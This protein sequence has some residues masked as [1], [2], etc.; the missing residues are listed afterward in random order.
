[1]FQISYMEETKV[2][3]FADTSSAEALF[4]K[5]SCDNIPCYML[6]DGRMVKSANLDM[7]DVAK[8]VVEAETIRKEQQPTIDALLYD[9][10]IKI[11][12]WLIKFCTEMNEKSIFLDKKDGLDIYSSFYM[13]FHE[14]YGENDYWSIELDRSRYT[15]RYCIHKDRKMS[16]YNCFD[17]KFIKAWP[18]LKNSILRCLNHEAEAS[19]LEINEKLDTLQNFEV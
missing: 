14:S 15:H 5:L 6:N 17:Y 3:V 12:E 11:F 1:M 18:Q 4:A 9:A 19:K 10:S 2:T 13:D 7:L 16:S 8:N